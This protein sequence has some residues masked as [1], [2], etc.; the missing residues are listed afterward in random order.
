MQVLKILF[1]LLEMEIKCFNTRH[2][3]RGSLKVRIVKVDSA[4]FFYN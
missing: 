3:T 2:L 1:H 4:I